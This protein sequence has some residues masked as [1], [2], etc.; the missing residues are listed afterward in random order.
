MTGWGG[1]RQLALECFLLYNFLALF[2]LS[3]LKRGDALVFDG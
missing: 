2:Y 1:G 3:S